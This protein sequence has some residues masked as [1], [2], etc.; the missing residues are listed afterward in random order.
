MFATLEVLWADYDQI[1]RD[2]R[3]MTKALKRAR[4]PL[5]NLYGIDEYDFFEEI[6]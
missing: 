1:K 5:L 4:K 2:N 6:E 3:V